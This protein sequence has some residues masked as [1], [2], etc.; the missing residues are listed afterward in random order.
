[1]ISVGNINVGGA[2]KTPVVIYLANRLAN[3]GRSVGILSRGY[4][5]QGGMDLV[6]RPEDPMPSASDAGDEPCLMKLRCPQ[7]HVLVSARRAQL[8]ARVCGQLGLDTLLLDD[9]FQH[10]SLARSLD[11]VVVD[12]AA[13]FGN[14]SLMPRGPLREPTSS[15][16]RA[17]L[18]W[19]RASA[20][21]ASG[22]RQLPGPRVR[23]SYS[24]A[25]WIDPGGASTGLEAL[26]GRRVVALSG[27]ARPQAFEA[28]L[29]GL[30]VEVARHFQVGDHRSFTP[31]LLA[32]VQ[33]EAQAQGG[34]CVTTE[35]DAMRLPAS[36]PALR[37]RMETRVL[38]G[39]AT[40]DGMLA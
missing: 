5:R 1:V 8:A 28:T 9:G 25:A 31:A 16:E 15:L 23:A 35:K 24:P 36:F 37:L 21:A 6:L 39:L 3:A 10:R 40:L 29:K 34:V 20:G 18:I 32:E 38:D 26:A 4:G 17:G 7:A 12:E 30:E 14:G 2:G 27:I 13:G 22:A 33:R 19:V 11:V